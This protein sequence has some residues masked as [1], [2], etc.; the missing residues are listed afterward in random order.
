MRFKYISNFWTKVHPAVF[1]NKFNFLQIIIEKSAIRP[2]EKQPVY[3]YYKNFTTVNSAVNIF[4][5]HETFL[6]VFPWA[7]VSLSINSIISSHC[8]NPFLPLTAALSQQLTSLSHIPSDHYPHP[9]QWRERRRSHSRRVFHGWSSSAAEELLPVPLDRLF[10]HITLLTRWCNDLTKFRETVLHHQTFPTVTSIHLQNLH[11][12]VYLNDSYVMIC[13]F[14]QVT[15]KAPIFTTWCRPLTEKT[16]PF[17]N[18]YSTQCRRT[19]QEFR[20]SN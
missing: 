10:P 7:S 20:A 19:N 4:L 1:K 15:T 5:T 2:T 17:Q 6:H 11:P 18:G 8:L 12:V 16:T 3:I 14:Y 13:S 9:L